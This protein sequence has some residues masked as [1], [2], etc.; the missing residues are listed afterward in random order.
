MY[1]QSG[2]AEGQRQ[3]GFAALAATVKYLVRRE[4]R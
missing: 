2:L 3:D 1:R 4:R